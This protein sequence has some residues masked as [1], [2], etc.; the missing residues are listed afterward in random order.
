MA[1]ANSSGHVRSVSLP[2]EYHP[3]ILSVEEKLQK[4]K[5]SPENLGFVRELYTRIDELIHLPQILTGKRRDL[6]DDVLDGSLRLLD[7]CGATID[8]FSQM[9]QSIQELESSLR[10]RNGFGSAEIRAYLGERKELNKVITKC[11]RKFPREEKKRCRHH[12]SS[13]VSDY[14]VVGMLREA[15]AM[16][17]SVFESLLSSV[18]YAKSRKCGGWLV[19]SK[20]LIS[21]SEEHDVVEDEDDCEIQKMDAEMLVVKSSRDIGMVRVHKIMK[22]LKMLEVRLEETEEELEF[23][24]RTLLRT[25]VSLLNILNH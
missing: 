12:G 10:R 17:L 24:F 2:A 5:R 13:T 22:R 7:L 4:L 3:L 11:S 20:L 1:T 14:D 18:S 16:S 8:V 19:V 21:K 6:V 25:R 23:V 15:E 9:K